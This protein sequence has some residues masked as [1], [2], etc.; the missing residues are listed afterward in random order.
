MN[1]RVKRKEKGK[2]GS[3]KTGERKRNVN[4]IGEKRKEMKYEKRTLRKGDK[5]KGKEV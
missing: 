5:E 1:K 4:R 3:V 2:E